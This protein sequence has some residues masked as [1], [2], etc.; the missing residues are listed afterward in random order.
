MQRLR[1]IH[2][3]GLAYLVY[4]SANHSRF[5]H[6]LGVLKLMIEII[7]SM[8]SRKNSCF[9]KCGFSEV[10]LLIAALLHDIGH[11]P[12]SHIGEYAFREYGK[13]FTGIRKGS[14]LFTY[15]TI[16]KHESRTSNIILGEDIFKGLN[17]KTW[18]NDTDIIPNENP[19][20]K[21]LNIINLRINKNKKNKI[22]IDAKNI[23]Y[24]IRGKDEND[25]IFYHFINGPIDIDKIDYILRESYFT[26][27]PF[28]KIDLNR[29]IE[30]YVIRNARITDEMGKIKDLKCQVVLNTRILASIIQF[31]IG[32]Q[33]NFL[34]ISYHRTVRIAETILKCIIDLIMIYLSEKFRDLKD[35]YSY[36]IRDILFHYKLMEDRD[37]L[38][39]FEIMIKKIPKAEK[40]YN[41]LMS[42]D[43]HK[44]FITK[45]TP[46]PLNE[47]DYKENYG[48]RIDKVDDKLKL[49]IPI[50]FLIIF[51]K[52]FK[53]KIDKKDKLYNLFLEWDKFNQNTKN[54]FNELKNILV[55]NDN[56]DEV[57]IVNT[58]NYPY[59]EKEISDDIR[60][61]F[62][63]YYFVK[64]MKI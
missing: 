11:Y 48:D 31:Y 60:K 13:H 51:D 8:K 42:R 64:L 54:S 49:C 28:G 35:D 41:R 47:D 55:N 36:L 24:L 46:L 12:F 43:L 58:I 17:D 10:E 63:I 5:E 37:L 1:G 30:G 3:Q 20:E 2:H 21:L 56:N 29:I 61:N 40:L 23:S 62:K 15:S 39:F 14:K 44:N 38:N 16:E 57:I 7:T 18:Y 59:I 27:T 22:S 26:G 34:T 52:K 45:S 32:R 33:I 4:P 53:A 19:F 6:S 25:E 50:D 9:E